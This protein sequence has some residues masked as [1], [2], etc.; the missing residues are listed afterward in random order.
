MP[1][2]AIAAATIHTGMNQDVVIAA[3]MLVKEA[4]MLVII[5]GR[6][7]LKDVSIVLERSSSLAKW[8][9]GSFKLGALFSLY[10][11]MSYPRMGAKIPMYTASSALTN[12]PTSAS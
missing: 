8:P 1:T 9:V 3:L 6:A 2:T 10:A 5:P 11:K 4:L 7:E 12:L